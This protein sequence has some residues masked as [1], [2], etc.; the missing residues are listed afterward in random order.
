M[1]DAI[2]KI[3]NNIE[4]KTGF[5][6]EDMILSLESCIRVGKYACH[7]ETEYSVTITNWDAE[8][9]LM[10]LRLLQEY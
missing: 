5:S 10:I 4:R 1:M 2:M 9:L 6:I 7:S 8:H 3:K